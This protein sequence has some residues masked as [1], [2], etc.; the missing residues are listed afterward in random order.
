MTLSVKLTLVLNACAS[1]NPS[2]FQYNT[3]RGAL[4]SRLQQKLAQFYARLYLS[5][6][7][8]SKENDTRFL[9]RPCGDMKLV[10]QSI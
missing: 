5:I 1:N 3:Q 2:T 9:T 10:K 8:L 4:R 6:F 7:Q